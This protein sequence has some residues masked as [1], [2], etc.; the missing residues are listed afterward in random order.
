MTKEQKEAFV[1]EFQE[2]LETAEAVYLTDFTGLD[3]KAMTALRSRIKRSGGEYLVVKNRLVKR[4]LADSGAPDVAAHLVGPTGVVFGDDDV[5]EAARTVADFA[6]DNGDKPVFKAGILEGVVLDAAK[7]ARIA[8]LPSREVL[9]SQVAGALSG[10]AS[11]LAG[12]LEAKVQEFAGLMEALR[13][14]QD[15]QNL[16]VDPN[17]RTAG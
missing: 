16:E 10:P 15:P 7:I 13:D 14:A 12:A 9:L 1:A 17:A 5:A 11:A 2:R 4:A 3:V 8:E 6:K